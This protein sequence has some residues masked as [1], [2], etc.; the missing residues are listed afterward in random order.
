MLPVLSTTCPFLRSEDDRKAYTL[1]YKR[2]LNCDWLQELSGS[3]RE[4]L[5]VRAEPRATIFAVS[6]SWTRLLFVR[7]YCSEIRG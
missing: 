7:S 4:R 6:C 5:E 3:E 1:L 2:T